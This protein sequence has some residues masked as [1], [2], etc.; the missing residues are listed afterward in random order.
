MLS[1]SYPGVYIEEIPSGVRPIAG[2]AT[3]VAAFVGYF[4]R[5]PLNEAVQI[6]SRGDFE[7]EFGGLRADSEAAYAIEQF[8]LNGG[9]QAWVT[10]T[11]A[12]SPASAAVVLQTDGA[13]PVLTVTATSPGAWGDN[14]RLDVDYGTTDPSA[15]FNLTVQE[16]D[17]D[18]NVA[19]NESFR[20]LTIAAG[21][22]HV[23]DV[24]NDGSK[25]IRV[26]VAGNATDGPAPT[27]TVSNVLT[28]LPAMDGSETLT[29]DLGG[30]T[31][32]TDA[33]GTPAPETLAA[34]AQRIQSLIR[35]KAGT[36]V[37]LAPFARNVTVKVGGSMA[38]GAQLVVKAGSGTASDVLVLSGALAT[39]F[40]LDATDHDNVQ[41]YALGG[42]TVGFQ[43]AASGNGQTG[44]D[45]SAPDGAA[46]TAALSAFDKVDLFNILSVPDTVRLQD[47]E[48]ASVIAEATAYC[49]KRRAFYVADMPHAKR[50]RDSMVEAVAW[51]DENATLRHPNAALY[52]P[53]PMIADPLNGYRPRAVAPSG[54]VAGL[55]SR[56]DTARGVWKAPAG[57][58]VTLSGVQKLEDKLNDA[59]NGVLN[60]LAVNCLR[61]IPPY[62]NIAWGSRTLVGADQ[63]ASEWKY[64][65]VR[66][67]AL[68]L[69]ESL[70]RGLHWVVFEP[71][72]EPLWGQIRL[73]TTA[74]MQNLFRQG[75]FQG[76]TPSEAYL[77]KCDRET[78]TQADIDLGIVNVV[79][80]FAPLKPAEFVI[81]KIQQLAGQTQA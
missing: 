78:T 37:G 69:E 72:D 47:A 45:G 11:A 26:V 9:S 68:F 3:S 62:G 52:Y 7:R 23:A 43:E 66:R 56:T 30:T 19:R 4:S 42:D 29:V 63:L 58:D 57:T 53:R 15:S 36:G 5:G 20:N 31:I 33:I 6:F 67:L 34:T 35:A 60:P 18:G 41:Q 12:G 32:T 51:I 39:D 54:T 17:G 2:V 79:V 55:Y 73:N 61:N 28:A 1:P 14:L 80:G 49:A 81:I 40:G 44:A 59:E 75:A 13:S 24:V 46:L 71:N 77:V 50:V 70:Y 64:V 65:P 27:G 21:P 8:F 10:R 25:L 22:R 76:Q 38:T 48:A 16:L 74:F